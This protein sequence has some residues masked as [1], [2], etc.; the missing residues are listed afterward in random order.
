[1]KNKYITLITCALVSFTGCKKYIDVNHDPNRP[2]DVKESLILAPVE[3]AISQNITAGGN[4]PIVIQQYLQVIALNQVPPNFG[5][6][7]MYHQDMD[8]DWY[9]FYTQVM[10]NLV[11]LNKKAEADGNANYAAI[12]KILLA[13]TLGSA[14]DV[15]GDVPFSKGFQGIAN[16]TPTY[17]SQES[18]YAQIQTLLD[19]AIADIAKSS[20]T[21][22]TGDDFYYTGDMSKWKKAAYTLKARYYMH[23]TK[24][25]GHTAAAQAQLALTALQNGMASNDDDMKM[26]FAGGAGAENPWQQNFLPGS[27]LVLASTFVDG[28]E[29]RKDPRKSKMV[30]PAIETGLYTGRVIGSDDIGSLEAYSLGGSFYASTSSNN[31]IV[32]YSEAL[33]LKAEATFVI[34]GATAAQPVY[35]QAVKSHMSKLGIADDVADSY[36]TSRGTLTSANAM[37]LIIEE[38]VVANFLSMENYVDWRRTGFPALTKVKNALSDIPRRVLYPQSEMTSNPQP[39][40]NAKLTDRVWWDAQ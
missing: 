40:Q 11:L 33:F 22:P 17:D 4:L 39:Q 29:A 34:S 5:T 36:L 14:T 27:T 31:Y 1:M 18:V 10:N 15:W 37:K 26:P 35:S 12:S 23:L 3:A 32:T 2:I 21:V 6:Y 38:K 24:A 16:V 7:L 28:F 30:A 9:N 13:Y 8:T 20:A 19:N 25:P